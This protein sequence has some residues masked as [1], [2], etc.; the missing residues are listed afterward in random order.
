[1]KFILFTLLLASILFAKIYT[2]NDI[3]EKEVAMDLQNE[4]ITLKGNEGKFLLL[5]FW[6]INCPPC[7]EEIPLFIDI[8]KKYSDKI[9]IVAIH[10]QNLIGVDVAR[11]FVQNQG[12][13]YTVVDTLGAYAFIND[14]QKATGWGGFIP[15]SILLAPNG[16]FIKYLTNHINEEELLKTI[17][18]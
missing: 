7:L 6:G 5:A 4:A 9:S 12:I 11:K 3:Y 13:N 8:Q 15:F 10:A 14:L 17:N 2:F 16:D 1:M 18:Q